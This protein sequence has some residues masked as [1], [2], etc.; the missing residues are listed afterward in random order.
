M[1]WQGVTVTVTVVAELPG[2]QNTVTAQADTLPLRAN[3]ALAL[4]VHLTTHTCT[5]GTQQTFT[6]VSSSAG[7]AVA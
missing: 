7:E 6:I 3:T 4:A 2:I 1:I 5:A